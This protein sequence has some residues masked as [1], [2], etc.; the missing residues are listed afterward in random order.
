MRSGRLTDEGAGDFFEVPLRW[1]LAYPKTR[2]EGKGKTHLDFVAQWCTP[3][4]N[5]SSMCSRF[6]NGP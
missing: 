3:P 6:S 4:R 1:R 2:T 5:L